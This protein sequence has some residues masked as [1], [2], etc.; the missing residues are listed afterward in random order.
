MSPEVAYDALGGTLVLERRQLLGLGRHARG[1]ASA[2]DRRTLR[3]A[4]ILD[5]GEI[6]PGLESL[7]QAV[8]A[9]LLE[10]ELTMR[11]GGRRIEGYGWL[12]AD[13]T[14]V[15]V[16][17][18][19][20]PGAPAGVFSCPT[21][22]LAHRLAAFVRLG[23][24]PTSYADGILAL[25]REAFERVSAQAGPTGDP[26]GEL[27][28]DGDVP[29]AWMCSLTATGSLHW[30]VRLWHPASH[31][32][33]FDRR[34]EVLDTRGEGLWVI[35]PVPD[36]DDMIAVVSANATAVW[37]LL[38]TLLPTEGEAERLRDGPGAQSGASPDYEVERAT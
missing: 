33:L 21:P 11:R 7:A 3:A 35:A 14:V 12:D 37:R 18:A 24:R 2:E 4:G 26:R 22:L 38:A 20:R 23:P 28:L 15:A 25:R 32:E 13:T 8:G 29:A 30:Q 5:G 36:A 1:S 9:P 19:E 34:C 16:P 27:E 6:A 17:P 10:I 31:G